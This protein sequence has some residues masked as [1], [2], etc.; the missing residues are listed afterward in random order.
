[1]QGLGWG[2][3]SQGTECRSSEVATEMQTPYDNSILSAALS[4]LPDGYY[5]KPRVIYIF[6]EGACNTFGVNVYGLMKA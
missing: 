2:W 4:S 1:M 5:S 6:M 3:S